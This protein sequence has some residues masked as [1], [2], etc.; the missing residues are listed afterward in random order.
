MTRSA[1]TV[2]CIT[3]VVTGSVDTEST[4]AYKQIELTVPHV[5]TGID[6]LDNQVPFRVFGRAVRGVDPFVLS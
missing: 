1:V 3:V 6:D 4:G 2:L 5:A